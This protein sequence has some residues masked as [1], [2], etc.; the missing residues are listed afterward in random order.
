MCGLPDRP[1]SLLNIHHRSLVR[2]PIRSLHTHMQRNHTLDSI[3]WYNSRNNIN[4]RNTLVNLNTITKWLYLILQTRLLSSGIIAQFPDSTSHRKR[5]PP[6]R[7]Q[8][9]TTTTCGREATPD[10]CLRSVSRTIYN[11]RP[12]NNI[13]STFSNSSDH[14][15]SPCIWPRHVRLWLPWA[16]YPRKSAHSKIRRNK[17]PKM[18][19]WARFVYLRGD[20]CRACPQ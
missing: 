6:V 18:R 15:I 10:H 2:L 3:N 4:P 13:R 11:S 14:Y 8:S 1:T 19:P 17:S 16:N 12:H 5:P 20:T 7:G 9:P